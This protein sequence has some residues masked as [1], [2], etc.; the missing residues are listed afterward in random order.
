MN[1][2]YRFLILIILLLSLNVKAGTVK[3]DKTSTYVPTRIINGDFSTEP[4]MDFDY[5]STNYTKVNRTKNH[6][7]T[8]EK[9]YSNKVNEGWNTTE[10]SIY[11]DTLFEWS[12]TLSDYGIASSDGYFVEM[13]AIN[14]ATLYQDL[15]TTPNDIMMWTLSH[16]A[17]NNAGDDT[18]DMHVEIGE[19]EYN[20]D[21]IVYATGIH[22]N[23][24]TNIKS[25][26]KAIYKYN[27]ISGTYGYGKTSELANLLLTK[28]TYGW[29]T[30]KGVYLVPEGQTV[31]RFA[32]VSDCL[33]PGGGN[34]LDNITFSTL[35]GNLSVVENDDSTVTIKGYWGDSDP[36]KKLVIKLGDDITKYDMSEVLNK[37]FTI[38]LTAKEVKNYNEVIVYHE[39]YS[40]AKRTLTLSDKLEVVFE[41]NDGSS[42]DTEYVQNNTKVTKP[43]NP[44]KDGYKFNGWYTDS[45]LKTRYNFNNLV[46]DNMTLYAKWS[47]NNNPETLDNNIIYLYLTLIS[48]IGLVI[49]RVFN[50]IRV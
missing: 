10:T 21:N 14:G 22:P 41:T 8:I 36:T 27:S 49:I 26:S 15:T 44:T 3:E 19:P 37:N 25:S 6:N 32:F 47:L 12:N 16:S 9:S 30:A 23:I 40:D 24:N 1:N 35:L 48:I 2:K 28:D 17:R 29:Y 33:E 38:T 42:I 43:S 20:G 11:I 5:N 4:W 18:Q 34:L 50:K 13:N 46:T 7:K 39:D 45:T 31:T